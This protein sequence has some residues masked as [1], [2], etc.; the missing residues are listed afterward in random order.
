MPIYEYQTS[1]KGFCDH[2]R[3]PF[4]VMQKLDDEP[5]KLCPECHNPVTRKIS[6]PNLASSSPSL[7]PENIEKH[8][9]TQFK[10]I[11]KGVYEKTA[12]KGPDYITDTDTK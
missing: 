6:P 11:D 7:S 8:G 9:Y 2:C 3:T 10:K 12:G 4:D 5:L 1:G